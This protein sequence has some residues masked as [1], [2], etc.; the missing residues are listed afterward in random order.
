MAIRINTPQTINGQ[1]YPG[2]MLVV[3]LDAREEEQLA[4]GGGAARVNLPPV[5][6]AWVLTLPADQASAAANRTAIQT[7]LDTYGDVQVRGSGGMVYLDSAVLQGDNTSLTTAA[8]TLLTNVPGQPGRLWGTK[9]SRATPAS[10]SIALS[11]NTATMAWPGHGCSEGDVVCLQGANGLNGISSPTRAQLD[12][13]AD[14]WTN[15][16]ILTVPDANTVTFKI[17]HTATAFPT[18]PITAVRHN[19]NVRASIE[20]DYN[21]RA[22]G[23]LVP[24]GRNRMAAEA[25]YIANGDIRIRARDVQKYV[26]TVSAVHGGYYEGVSPTVANS[27]TVKG[28]GPITGNAVLRGVGQSP[29]DTA[30]LQALEPVDFIA[31]MP[32]QGTIRGAILRECQATLTDA[33]SGPLVIY[34]DDKYLTDG[35]VIE[36]ATALSYGPA[37]SGVFPPA[38]CI[39]EG[40]NFDKTKSRL[41]NLTVRGGTF[42]SSDAAAIELRTKLQALTLQGVTLRTPAQNG[43]R[44]IRVPGGGQADTLLVT[45]TVVN[46]GSWPT[47]GGFHAA[48]V[49]GSATVGTVHFRRCVIRGSSSLRWLLTASGSAVKTI[50]VEDCDVAGIDVLVRLEQA[51]SRVILRGA[52]TFASVLTICNF[53]TSGSLVIEGSLQVTGATNGVCRAEIAGTVVD[54]FAS[55][56]PA[57]TSSPLFVCLTTAEVNLRSDV[58]SADIGATGVKK[59]AGNRVFSTTA[60]GAIPANVPVVC[61]GTNWV[62]AVNPTA[63]LSF[64]GALSAATSGTLSAAWALPSGA[65]SVTFSDGSVRAVTLTNGATTATWTG[66]VTAAANATY[67]SAA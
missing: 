18:G 21:K 35:V 60:R 52:N 49:S 19:K 58:L 66:A 6:G 37:V 53:R 11:G 20:L 8:G 43:V 28:Y 65:V 34:T 13:I 25:C 47:A 12:E 23:G 59:T 45:D 26:L 51:G 27:D 3:G 50:I 16:P 15:F 5:S 42:G 61:D 7:A 56:A 36:D 14:W 57:L 24:A 40:V 67:L 39:R 2:G 41:R 31:Y 55:A 29:E 46:T 54:I 64:T 44:L 4:Q 33:G 48:E 10:V 63:P 9:A 22:H 38:L 32:S 62:N 17:S 30:S 1:D